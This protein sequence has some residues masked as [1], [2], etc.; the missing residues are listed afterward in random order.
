MNSMKKLFLIIFS[1]FLLSGCYD[2]YVRDYDY[3]GVYIAYQYDVRT[4]VVGEGMK[5]EIGTVLGGV[6]NNTKD[7]I[8][9]FRIDDNLV[10]GDL[11]EFSYILNEE[12]GLVEEGSSFTAIDGMYGRA[13]VGDLSES[14]V[15]KLFQ[16]LSLTGLAVMPSDYYMLSDTETMVIKNGWHTGTVTVKADSAAFLADPITK[17]PYYAFGFR[18]ESADAD[19]VLRS[20]SFSIIAVKYE[21]M[22]FGN[23]WHGGVTT[24]RDDATGDI[25]STDVYPTSI[26]Q[27]E[28]RVYTLTTSAPFALTTNRLGNGSGSLLLTQD[29]GKITVTSADG[30]KTIEEIEGGSTF[31][32]AK[33]L[34]N[35]KLYLNYKYG[36]GDGT[37]TFVQDTLTFR[38]RI[39]DGVNEWQDE[40]PQHYE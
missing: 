34:Q 31:N 10:N 38:N 12:E 15:T 40:N 8:V 35:R 16:D 20:K 26:P 11:K 18:I 23:Y 1:M 36:N 22:L 30:S 19:T 4:F 39:R 7:R 14:Y 3:S 28:N 33:L 24:I 13:P 6:I 2:D 25:I 32:Q 29:G 37:S 27:D 17:E 9:K 5:F 21:N